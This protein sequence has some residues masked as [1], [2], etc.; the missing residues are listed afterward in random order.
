[1]D[2]IGHVRA[3]ANTSVWGEQLPQG[4]DVSRSFQDAEEMRF[5]SEKRRS[6]S[7]VCSYGHWDGDELV[8]VTVWRPSLR[9]QLRI[10]AV[11]ETADAE[12]AL[13]RDLIGQ[14]CA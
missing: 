12:I 5:K 6:V 14:L 1:M 3:L 2:A 11:F 8:C 9:E 4:G 7:P 13:R 10:A